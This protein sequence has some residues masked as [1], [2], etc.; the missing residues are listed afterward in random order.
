MYVKTDG[1]VFNFCKNKCHKN[2]ID[3]H[4]IPRRTGWT[5]PYMREK[6]SKMSAKEKKVSKKKGQPSKKRP[7]KRKKA[8]ESKSDNEKRMPKKKKSPGKTKE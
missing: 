5:Q 3:L 1:T 8:P 4:R 2:L 6:T 7:L